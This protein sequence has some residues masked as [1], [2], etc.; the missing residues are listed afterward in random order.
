M[1][2]VLSVAAAATAQPSGVTKVVGT[3]PSTNGRAMPTGETLDR[4]AARRAAERQA[5]D[6]DE[7]ARLGL[8]Q[9]DTAPIASA[10]ALPV[11]TPCFPIRHVAIEGA[12]VPRLS[13][14]APFAA[15]YVGQCVGTAG[16]DTILRSLEGRSCVAGSRPHARGCPPRT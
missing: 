5:A 9:V 1:I 12:N 14:V 2:V 8:S 13:W 10:A 4:E 3:P 7:R 16:L 11:E 15:R 6:R